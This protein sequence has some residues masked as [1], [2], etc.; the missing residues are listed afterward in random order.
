VITIRTLLAS[1]RSGLDQSTT[2]GRRIQ[3]SYVDDGCLNSSMSVIF[4]GSH[5][6]GGR[7]PARRKPASGL[8]TL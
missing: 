4:P 3:T 8:R 6:T 1:A 2:S 5:R 7:L